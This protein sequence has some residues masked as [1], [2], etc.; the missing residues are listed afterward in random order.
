MKHIIITLILLSCICKF[1]IAQSNDTEVS[2]VS[3]SAYSSDKIA[4]IR[5]YYVQVAYNL[6]NKISA[7]IYGGFSNYDSKGY[8]TRNLYVG[9][10][11]KYYFFEN[12]A[13]ISP[14]VSAKLGCNFYKTEFSSS[15]EINKYGNPETPGK[16]TSNEK[17]YGIYGG[18]KVKVYK[19]LSVF[20]EVGYGKHDIVRFGVSI[21][22]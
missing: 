22:L 13:R 5:P 19:P 12:T 2:K 14:Y 7:G 1:G 3:V 9:S 8:D 18:V 16:L 6:T 11:L 4:G 10:E 17:D 15:S 20:G 21:S